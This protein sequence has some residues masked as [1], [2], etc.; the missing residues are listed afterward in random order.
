MKPVPNWMAPLALAALLNGCGGGGS[1]GGSPPSISL[2]ITPATIAAGNS[3]SLN[4]GTS[5]ATGCTASGAWSGNRPIS[6]GETVTPASTGTVTYI[7]TCTNAAGTSSSSSSLVVTPAPDA[8]LTF[9]GQVVD[10][11]VANATV[12]VR[13]GSRNFTGTADGTGHY[14]IT[15]SIPPTA[16]ADFVSIE[17]VGSAA[18]PEIR[19]RSLIGPF[20][21]LVTQ[22]GDHRLTAEEN[23]N[24]NI[25][26]VS[27]A[28]AVLTAEAN[29]GS[30]PTDADTLAIARRTLDQ[31]QL[32]ELATVIRLVV[33]GSYPLPSGVTDTLDLIDDT[34]TRDAFLAIAR[35]AANDASF[36][37]A[38]TTVD[39]DPALTPGLSADALPSTLYLPIAGTRTPEFRYAAFAG[40]IDGFEFAADGSGTYL[41]SR[42]SV[43]SLRWII[44][45]DRN[46]AISFEP[47][48]NNAPE[49]LPFNDPDTGLGIE[50]S[51]YNE[52][53]SI[54]I[55]RGLGS[56][57]T[58]TLTRLRHCEDPRFDT[59]TV[60]RAGR[61][62]F[63]AEQATPYVASEIAGR[64]FTLAVD[65]SDVPAMDTSLSNG[66]T[67]EVAAFAV[68]GSGALIP[69]GRSF[70]WAVEADGTLRV[71]MPNGVLSRYRLLFSPF[72]RAEV[73]IA[74]HRYPDGRRLISDQLG[75]TADGSL[76]F[77]DS[78]TPGVY[79]AFGVGIDFAAS[80]GG[81]SP[82]SPL[83]KG[84]AFQ[85]ET[86]GRFKTRFDEVVT[87]TMSGERVRNALVISQ[88]D[89]GA[90]ADGTI[91]I[92]RYFF[93]DGS[94]N[95]SCSLDSI[96]PGCMLLEQRTLIP[97]SSGDGNR[98]FWLQLLQLGDLGNPVTDAM[99]YVAQ[100]RFYDFAPLGDYEI[101]VAAGGAAALRK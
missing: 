67:H 74:D 62:W 96:N 54:V 30:A 57:A 78:D 35:S 87:D 77:S 72:A 10:S 3:A 45:A 76:S 5:D 85:F 75:Y 59:L 34:A 84:I 19:F 81:A 28:E 43:T 46:L 97:L 49:E 71:T 41:S 95:P 98:H 33:D 79:Y 70:A 11:P 25:T 4:W 17:A 44:D 99:P 9:E 20:A 52:V 22:S 56:G 23:F 100:A 26:N 55:R 27:T 18:D 82:G 68:D 93:S 51:C 7:L 8:T 29:G 50:V 92:Q 66:L 15:A 65:G 80:G 86:G 58:R 21:A 53:R 73:G 63:P 14:S 36:V 91:T 42:G 1:G 31:D 90:R 94:P 88:R 2:S 39:T 101:P 12:T 40:H 24:V 89:W 83:L 47:V 38:R 48:F 13:V 16:T 60:D 6:G 69:S 37:A 61:Y 64:A 32:L